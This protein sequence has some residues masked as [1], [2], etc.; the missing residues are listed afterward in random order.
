MKELDLHLKKGDPDRPA[1]VFIHGLGMNH[2]TWTNPPEARMMGGMLSLR[3]LLKAFLNDPSTLYHD[4]QKLGCTAIAW[5]QRRPVGPVREAEAEL[6]AVLEMLKHIPCSSVVLV[7]HSRGGLV[8][9][10]VL[11]RVNSH[12]LGERIK[13]L[14]TICTPNAGSG[15][16]RWAT[17]LSPV[18]ERFKDALPASGRGT[19]LKSLDRSLGF[20]SS[21][22]ASELL[23][24]S[25]FIRSLPSA[26]PEGVACYSVGGTNPSLINSSWL[27]FPESIA[28]LL[29]DGA[30]PE[31]LMMDRGDALVTAKSAKLPGAKK[32]MNFHNNHLTILVDPKV[33]E[34]LMEII[35]EEFL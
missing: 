23:P 32:H 29:P 24:E 26:P 15:L 1:F 18:A 17:T 30:V 19:F 9:R 14:I 31:E 8:A 25:D 4:V 20:I 16:A 34:A 10:S 7:C 11:S 2:L 22:G 3:S 12:G 33:R 27:V 6:E 5:S 13:G 28:R 35:K 21:T